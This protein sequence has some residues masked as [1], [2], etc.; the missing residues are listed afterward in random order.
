[1]EITKKALNHIYQN[2]RQVMDNM[3]DIVWAINNG[4]P[5]TSTL[6]DKLKNYGYELLTPL[7]I[8]VTYKIN[9]E[10]EKKL[11]HMEARKNILMIAKEAMNNIA[12]YSKATEAVV[13]LEIKHSSFFLTVSDNGNGFTTATR[14]KGN[15]LVNMQHRTESMGGKF[16]I[17][18]V[19]DHGTT[20][21]CTIPVT[22]ISNA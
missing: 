19:L 21:T 10:A 2:S 17:D 3:S 22:N 13:G 14:R 15:G 9:N 12:R 1:M 7:N 16:T 8:N 4:S 20:L 5:G 18:S 11:N 6:E